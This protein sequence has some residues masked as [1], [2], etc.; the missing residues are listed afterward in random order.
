M[1]GFKLKIDWSRR[2]Q[3][4]PDVS[5]LPLKALLALKDAIDKVLQNNCNSDMFSYNDN[6]N[7]YHNT[8]TSCNLD[9]Q[10]ANSAAREHQ[11]RH[12]VSYTPAGTLS[13]EMK[14]QDEYNKKEEGILDSSG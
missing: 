8:P 5:Q 7:I 10:L 1:F 12:P 14:P 13:I 4:F 9:S 6:T 2:P 3:P 11:P